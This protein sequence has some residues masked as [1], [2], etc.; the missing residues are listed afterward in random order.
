MPLRIAMISMHTSPLAKPGVG[1][2]GGLN[3]YVRE[4]SKALAT[5]DVEVDIFTRSRTPNVRRIVALGDGV[6]VITLPAGPLRPVPKEQLPSYVS[7][8]AAI[9]CASWPN[10]AYRM[11]LC[12]AITGYPVWSACD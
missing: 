1:D 7:R 12:T 3:V 11:I 5:L 8:F 2:A 10:R 9:S 6:R 4:L